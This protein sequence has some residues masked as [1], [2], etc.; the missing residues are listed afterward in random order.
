VGSVDHRPIGTGQVG[1]ITGQVQRLYF[2][3]VRGTMARYAHW[4]TP[5]YKSGATTYRNGHEAPTGLPVPATI[6]A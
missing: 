2:D 4:C 5:A 6:S 1:P 3:V